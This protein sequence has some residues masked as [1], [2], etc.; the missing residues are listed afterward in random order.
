MSAAATL[1]PPELLRSVFRCP[2]CP[3]PQKSLQRHSH[4][5]HAVPASALG[6]LDNG[7]K[8]RAFGRNGLNGFNP[9]PSGKLQA[10][11]ACPSRQVVDQHSAHPARSFSAAV[12]RPIQTEFICKERQK[13]HFASALRNIRRSSV[14]NHS[15]RIC[16]LANHVQCWPKLLV[17]L[18][19]GPTCN[20]HWD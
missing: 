10:H 18:T 1:D 4:T 7:A 5:R 15:A 8:Q 13:V 11:A 9:L 20:E 17:V 12:R 2:I 6:R 16:H 14:D 3:A 19:D